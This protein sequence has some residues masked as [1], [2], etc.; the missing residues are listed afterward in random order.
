MSE[1]RAATADERGQNED[2]KQ[3]GGGPVLERL[4]GALGGVLVVALLVFLIY[5]A[6]AVSDGG[7]DLSATVSGIE[8]VGGQY[9]THV[10][11]E[12]QGGETASGVNLAG[13]L[14][15]DGTTVEQATTTISYVPLKSSRR[16]VLVFARDPREAKLSVRAAGYELP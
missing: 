1:D 16:A 10:R 11:V 4:V 8:H 6:V 5:Q 15:V 3:H 7:P 9:V 14:S 12:N 13:T 2:S